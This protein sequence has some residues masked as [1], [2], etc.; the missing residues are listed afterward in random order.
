MHPTKT[1]ERLELIFDIGMIIMI[2]SFAW[3]VD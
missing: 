2:I 1:F 3:L